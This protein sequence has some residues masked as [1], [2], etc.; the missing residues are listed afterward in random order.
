M[1]RHQN[2]HL[3][4]NLLSYLSWP[5]LSS[6]P[7]PTSDL[8]CYPLPVTHPSV[9][10][11]THPQMYTCT[12]AHT[13]HTYVHEC[14]CTHPPTHTQAGM[15]TCIYSR[16]H[17][18]Q[19]TTHTITPPSNNRQTLYNPWSQHETVTVYAFTDCHSLTSS[20]RRIKADRQNC[21]HI[22]LSTTSPQNAYRDQESFAQCMTYTFPARHAITQKE[23]SVLFFSSMPT[24]WSQEC[25]T[26]Q[27]RK[28][29]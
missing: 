18:H 23:I 12:H 29:G 22:I 27:S 2:I 16:E 25:L 20:S 3:D 17:V 13:K 11:S 6:V 4:L 28:K 9:S 7:Q 8:H 26:E 19:H 5:I 10:Q 15:H 14:M 24:Y 21:C 1:V